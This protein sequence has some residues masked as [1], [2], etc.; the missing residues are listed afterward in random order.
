MPNYLAR[1]VMHRIDDSDDYIE[2]HAEMQSIG[3]NQ[4]VS[5]RDPRFNPVTVKMPPGTYFFDDSIPRNKDKF[6]LVDEAYDAVL[7]VVDKVV[8]D[9]TKYIH[10]ANHPPSVL[11]IEVAAARWNL[12]VKRP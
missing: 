4:Y 3:F 5:N 10:D 7:K 11:V 8:E 9:K 12:E 1:V 6:A 2:L